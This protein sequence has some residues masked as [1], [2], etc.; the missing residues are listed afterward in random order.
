MSPELAL[1][2][3]SVL[4]AYFTVVEFKEL[5]ALFEVDLHALWEHEPGWL[6][7]CRELTTKLDHG[8]SRRL[9]DNVLELAENRNSDNVAHQTWER[10]DF[11]AGVTRVIRE[12]RQ[13][14]EASAAPSE[15]T[16]AAGNIFSAKSRVRELLDT[17]TAEVFV[18][19]PYVGVGTLDCL[20]NLKVPIR[21]LTGSHAQ[22]VDPGFDRAVQA[23]VGEGHALEV[24]QA[25]QLH[26]RHLVF[27]GRCWLVG[28]SLKDA[29][30][31]PF[32]CIEIFDKAA[33]IADLEARWG[34]GSTY[35]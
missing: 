15:I 9:V 34:Q 17:A 27:N 18:V 6:A 8:N 26:D 14:L 33:V 24:R 16:V 29:G 12:A 25:P 30:K 35:P 3:V 7:I 31:K 13:L 21:L 2:L 10:R 32:N 11:H 22:A 28:G 19:D 20:C 5:A 4:E 1:K 23:F